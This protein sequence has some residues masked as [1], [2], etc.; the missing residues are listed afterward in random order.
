MTLVAYRRAGAARRPSLGDQPATATRTD[1][2][3]VVGIV[4]VHPPEYSSNGIN[5]GGDVL[6]RER[7][8]R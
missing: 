3:A 2:D 4:G 7:R 6:N 5:L 1:C 8:R